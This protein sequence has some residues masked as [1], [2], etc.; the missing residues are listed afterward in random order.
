MVFVY[1]AGVKVFLIEISIR[2]VLC[3]HEINTRLRERLSVGRN[4]VRRSVASKPASTGEGGRK[5]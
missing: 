4:E 2:E 5:A 3:G 1:L